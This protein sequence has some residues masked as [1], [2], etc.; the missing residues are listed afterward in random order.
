MSSVRQ[1]IVDAVDA[2]LKTIKIQNG[3]DSDLGNSV[4]RWPTNFIA[5]DKTTALIYRD[6]DAE[7]FDAAHNKS[8][9]RLN[10]VAEIMARLGTITD[11]EIRKMLNDVSRALG[12][13]HTLGGLAITLKITAHSINDME[14]TEKIIG[15]GTINFTVHYRTNQ[16]EI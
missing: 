3:Y 16:F 5:H 15:A 10:F 14:Q 11:S 9:H 6:L 12:V 8:D 1:Q 4:F 13:D 7:V 2:R